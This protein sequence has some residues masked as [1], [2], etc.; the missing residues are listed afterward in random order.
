VAGVTGAVFV[1]GFGFAQFGPITSVQPTKFGD[2]AAKSALVAEW[3]ARFG[4]GDYL[5]PQWIGLPLALMMFIGFA[6]SWGVFL[7]PLLYRDWIVRLRFPLY[8]LAFALPWP[9]VAAIN[10]WLVREIGRQPWAA[11]GLL[12]VTDAVTQTDGRVLLASFVGFTALLLTLAVTNWILLIRH[13]LR[14][15]HDLALGREPDEPDEAAP[16]HPGTPA[17]V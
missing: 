14:G 8:L 11:Y 5:P 3:T 6:L 10:G 17:L 12:P 15:P 9:F 16:A 4:P 1:M 2:E 7:V 13:A